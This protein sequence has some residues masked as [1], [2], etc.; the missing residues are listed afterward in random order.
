MGIPQKGFIAPLLLILLAVLLVSG[1]AYVYMQK[2]QASQ[3]VTTNPATQTTSTTQTSDS[4][5]IDWVTYKDADYTNN[6]NNFTFDYPAA[7]RLDILPDY[8]LQIF[9]S[10]T[11]TGA[12]AYDN[13]GIVV[14]IGKGA[15]NNTQE[16]KEWCEKSFNPWSPIFTNV[17]YLSVDGKKA[18]SLDYS[19]KEEFTGRRICITMGND[20]YF[21]EGHPVNSRYM[22]IFERLVKSFQF[23]K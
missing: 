5:I 22:S 19:Y 9:S 23:T 21:L 17:Y 15:I 11:E 2:N 14:E 12:T 7:W 1:G 20:K 16:V 3:S 4:Q 18:Y 13:N 6:K 10:S 8:S